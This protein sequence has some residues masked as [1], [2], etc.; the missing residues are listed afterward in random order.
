MFA[1]LDANPWTVTWFGMR[2][3]RINVV[4]QSLALLSFVWRDNRITMTL[5]TYRDDAVSKS[6][7]G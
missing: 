7:A 5:L 3:G 4:N 6:F 2:I 1:S